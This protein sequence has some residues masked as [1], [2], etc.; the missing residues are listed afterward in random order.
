MFR[1]AKQE[2]TKSTINY[3]EHLKKSQEAPC[4]RFSHTWT[5]LSTF[6][7]RPP[8]GARR[9]IPAE[10][11]TRRP[12]PPAAPPGKQASPGGNA[13]TR[14]ARSLGV[15]ASLGAAERRGGRSFEPHSGPA[16]VNGPQGRPP[17]VGARRRPP[18]PLRE[19]RS[20]REGKGQ[21]RRGKRP[22]PAPE[23][24]AAAAAPLPPATAPSRHT[25]HDGRTDE[26]G[27]VLPPSPPPPRCSSQSGP[28]GRAARRG[29][30]SG[31]GGAAPAPLSEWPERTVGLGGD[32]PGSSAMW[33]S[34]ERVLQLWARPGN[35]NVPPL[36][37]SCA[38]RCRAQPNKRVSGVKAA[39][40]QE[41]RQSPPRGA[42]QKTPTGFPL[43][44]HWFPTDFPLV[45]FS[46]S[47]CWDQQPGP[48]ARWEARPGTGSG[49]S[50]CPPQPFSRVTFLLRSNAPQCP[51]QIYLSRIYARVRCAILRPHHP[52]S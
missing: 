42:G 3:P 16:A 17:P 38:S 29:G 47:S 28:G 21:E 20:R 2:K 32:W 8:G 49:F 50:E 44:S 14:R 27:T 19:R 25:H 5:P 4:S 41:R 15:P 43:V 34:R 52:L 31:A 6:S 40:D 26:R 24:G 10:N 7:S 48:T 39:P 33:Q 45:F 12:R 13:P 35:G 37:T 30:R 9:R 22:S 51:S 36:E 18:R 23:A 46:C 11:P 1:I